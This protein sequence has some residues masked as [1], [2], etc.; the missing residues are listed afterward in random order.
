M[1]IQDNEGELQVGKTSWLTIV[2]LLLR[3]AILFVLANLLASFLGHFLGEG[4]LIVFPAFLLVWF[5]VEL[6]LWSRRRRAVA[7]AIATSGAG[8]QVRACPRCGKQVVT[9][10]AACPDCAYDIE[11]GGEQSM[12]H[13]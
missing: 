2:W 1:D 8:I 13:R 6:S 12:D 10:V 3:F 11:R 4:N 9:S 5:L 7:E